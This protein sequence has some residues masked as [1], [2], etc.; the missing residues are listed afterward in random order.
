MD[1]D[2]LA[3]AARLPRDSAAVDENGNSALHWA[4]QRLDA[5]NEV[6]LLLRAGAVANT[7]NRWGNT[8]LHC[9]AW[10]DKGDCCRLLLS[11]GAAVDAS[12][13][14]GWTP[15][16]VAASRGSVACAVRL[17]GAGAD[18]CARSARGET[19]ADVAV[20]QGRF[21]LASLL[22]KAEAA[23]ARW[24]GLRRAALAAWVGT[25]AA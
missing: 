5:S 15:L 16:H 6:V 9:A 23:A 24:A 7:C 17:L 11:A 21:Q 10:Y 22:R 1:D 8:P 14:H 12:N 4:V 19:P 20:T 18:A 3:L 25:P 13:D 2:A